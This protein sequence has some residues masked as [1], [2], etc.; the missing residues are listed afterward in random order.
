[1]E[2][3]LRSNTLV[4]NW[5]LLLILVVAVF[6][7][8]VPLFIHLFPYSGAT[9]LG[10]VLLPMFYLPFIA[11]VF[12]RLRVAFVAAILAPFINYMITGNPAL[13]IVSLL[14][15]EL[16]IFTLVAS[17]FLKNSNVKWITAP[18][19]Y[20]VT[21]GI[22]SLVVAVGI[23]NVGVTSAD[24]F[25]LSIINGLPGI[26]VLLLINVAVVYIWKNKR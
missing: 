26:L 9:P 8:L 23:F 10:A 4:S 11:L 20:V 12:F 2:K 7:A 24:F 6:S 3:H 21:K 16:A 17:Q 14:S 19:S 15:F 5:D 22:S 18:L 13:G 1:M 25:S